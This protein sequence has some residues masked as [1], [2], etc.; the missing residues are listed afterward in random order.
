M[1]EVDHGKIV[2]DLRVEIKDV[3]Y[4]YPLEKTE[5][6][7][8]FMSNIDRV[9]NFN[10]RTIHFFAANQDF[11]PRV[12][13][14]ML[15][16]ALGK[17][18]V[19][20]NF[21]A[22]RMS[23]NSETG[24]LEFNCNGKGVG[25]IAAESGCSVDEIGDLTCHNPVF[26]QLIT[27]TLHK[28]HHPSLDNTAEADDY[29]LAIF[30]VTSFT[31]GGFAIGISMNHTTLDGL[32][33]R[34]FLDNLAAVASGKPLPLPP[35]NNRRLLAARSPL[36]VTSP[37][38]ELLQLNN[39]GQ[40]LVEATEEIL[41]FK[42]FRLTSSHVSLLKHKAKNPHVT[43]A[44]PVSS[45]YAVTALIWRCKALSYHHHQQQNN[46]QDYSLLGGGGEDRVSTILYA[47]NIRQRI[48][49]ALDAAYAGNAVL[50]AYASAKCGEI[51]E[52]P[53][54]RMVEMVAEGGKRMTDEYARLGFTEVDYPWG[55][56][57][58]SCPLIRHRKENVLVFPHIADKQAVNVIVALP[59]PQMR[60]FASLFDAFLSS[61][62]SS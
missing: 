37:H 22:G 43:S 45:F 46:N 61:L 29:P 17:V 58:Y 14:Q 27:Q 28:Q 13:T 39:N 3:C 19:P 35:C 32:S 54:W 4:V 47:V 44:P 20:Y 31:C 25:F 12:V 24:R 2:D 41:D 9:L 1:G 53:L 8:M 10:V 33:V 55:K 34:V 6:S 40:V 38:P 51:E 59:P 57:I 11:S 5:T 16:E 60:N 30:Q 42:I 21:L 7:S 23:T 48:S 50:T 62:L 52:A 15:K 36:R 26:G 49:P 56:P 18:L